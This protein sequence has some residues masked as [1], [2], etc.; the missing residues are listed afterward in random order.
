M[1]EVLD[2]NILTSDV[3]IFWIYLQEK[4]K[5]KAVNVVIVTN[6]A[7]GKTL[8]L[9]PIQIIP[10]LLNMLVPDP[11]LRALLSLATA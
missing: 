11:W 3:V 10:A 7:Q 2:V 1:I 6:K 9:L 5:L 8:I 4:L